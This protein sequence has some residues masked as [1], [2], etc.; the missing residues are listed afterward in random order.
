MCYSA[1]VRLRITLQTSCVALSAF[2]SGCGERPSTTTASADT[3]GAASGA[4]TTKG[5]DD[6]SSAPVSG[7]MTTSAMS[8]SS[9]SGS[10]SSSSDGSTVGGSTGSG[11][12]EDLEGQSCTVWVQDCPEGEKCIPYAPCDGGGW[13][14]EL[15]IPVAKNPAKLGETCSVVGS[16]GGVDNCDRG[17]F[18]WKAYSQQSGVCVP[19]CMGSGDSYFCEIPERA[20]VLNSGD[21]ILGWCLERCDPL[22]IACSTSGELCVFQHTAQDFVCWPPG[23]GMGQHHEPCYDI[24]AC[25]PGFVCLDSG[26]AEECDPNAQGCCEPYCDLNL[27]DAQCPGVNQ[28]CL[29]LF[30][31]GMAPSGDEDVGVCRLPA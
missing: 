4:S 26:A 12:C 11:D 5:S 1:H 29:P 3:L 28:Q 13:T 23:A 9:S 16:Y 10:G 19:L 15:C 20:C 24:A 25:A 30:E 17:L 2:A 18:C 6:S 27:P 14:S 22:L 31:A 7:E 8:S 21:S